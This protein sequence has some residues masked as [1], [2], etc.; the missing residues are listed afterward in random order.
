MCS[1]DGDPMG[2]LTKAIDELAAADVGSLTAADLTMR[3][4][5]IWIL[6]GDLDPE[7]AR[8]AARY[9]RPRADG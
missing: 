8:R 5:S 9:G 2:K 3:V 7:L 4:A 1:D 6:V